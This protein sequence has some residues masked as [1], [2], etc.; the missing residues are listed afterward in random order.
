MSD[1]SC[2]PIR[3]LQREDDAPGHPDGAAAAAYDAVFRHLHAAQHHVEVHMY[4]WRSDSIGNRIG[5]AVLAAADRGVKIRIIKD[6]GAFMYERIE[7]NRKSFFNREI[8][9]TKRLSHRLIAPTFP[10]T[11]VTDEYGFALGEK[12]MHHPG[13]EMQWVNKTHTKY[14]L[15]DEQTL[16]T[17]SINIED[18]HSSYRDYMVELRGDAH[19]K[20][21]RS[22]H[23]G[24][25]P[26]DAERPIDFLW[27]RHAPDG[28]KH[29]EIK[30]E[31]LRRIAM[32]RH[33]I[34]IEMAYIGDEDVSRAIVQAAR[35]GVK[36]T[37]LFSAKANIGNDINFKTIHE[38]YRAA[39]VDVYLSERML[40]SKLMFFDDETVVLGSCNLSV[41]SLQKAGELS[42]VIR[43]QP[44]F[45]QAVKNVIAQ[46]LA[47]SR[48]VASSAE[49][50]SY[51]RIIA[52]LQQLHQKWNPN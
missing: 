27:N 31:L 5:D 48:K 25:V 2:E 50:S 13:I 6:I 23:S 11:R 46:R 10:D 15:F 19:I 12:L 7:M 38:I 43:D 45:V 41:F 33:S 36:V 39:P 47:A 40:H 14:Y 49:L 24:E 37:F 16:V 8:P 32:A 3:L 26:Y 30:S 4:V 1:E 51:N 44:G 34:Y 52:I 20:R 35:R 17:G 29:F 28:T 21:F 18:R 9:W 22:R 42:L